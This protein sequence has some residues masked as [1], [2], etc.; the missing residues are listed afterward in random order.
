MN[1]RLSYSG[2]VSRPIVQILEIEGPF[3]KGR[4]ENICM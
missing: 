1:N 3:A 4:T 2:I